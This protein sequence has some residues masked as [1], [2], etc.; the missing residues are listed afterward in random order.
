MQSYNNNY[1]KVTIPSVLSLQ[2]CLFWITLRGSTQTNFLKI[3]WLILNQN[4]YFK[5]QFVEFKKTFNIKFKMKTSQLWN[6]YMYIIR[7][8]WFATLWQPKYKWFLSNKLCVSIDV[9][10]NSCCGYRP[11][12]SI[13]APRSKDTSGFNETSLETAVNLNSCRIFG[14]AV[15]QFWYRFYIAY[16]YS[17]L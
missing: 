10:S 16:I 2:C 4:E 17:Y 6:M 8:S 12:K 13:E 5:K 14:F 1:Y 3:L 15:W 9:S 7:I 11:S